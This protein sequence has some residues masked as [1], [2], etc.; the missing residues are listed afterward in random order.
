MAC[1][2]DVSGDL[3]MMTQDWTAGLPHAT[4]VLSSASHD[5]QRWRSND[6][7]MMTQDWTAG[8]SVLPGAGPPAPE[9]G[10]LKG[11]HEQS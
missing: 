7:L 5:P 11:N 1:E 8:A 6:L 10:S 4:S 3:L 9:C 2:D